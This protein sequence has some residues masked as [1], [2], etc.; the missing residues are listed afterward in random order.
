M[1]ALGGFS[2]TAEVFSPLPENRF[3]PP[4]RVER[5]GVAGAGGQALEPR[6]ELQRVVHR[7]LGR[8]GDLRVLEAGCGSSSHII[9]PADAHMVGIDISPEQLEKN[10]RLDEKI[11]GDVQAHPFDRDSF[12]LIV[13]WDVLEHLPKP[14]D[15][16]RSF[17]KGVKPNG[18]I[19]LAL[20]NVH[21]V[22]GLV[23]KFTPH[24][25]H[26]WFYRR[27]FGSRTA[28]KPGFAP[29]PTFLRLAVSP[30]ALHRF[31]RENGLIVEFAS[32]YESGMVKRIK[33]RSQAFHTV[34]RGVLG[35]VRF[36]SLGTYD[37]SKSDSILV[38]RKPGPSAA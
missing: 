11:L 34:Y 16:L 31:A 20:P 12:D 21:S 25:F 27:I 17:V 3:H 19:V 8:T 37:G 13:C 4:K 32:V 30:P 2:K 14:K 26:V 23:T 18:L 22:K 28:G 1:K 29:F 10:A 33:G 6:A 15:A 35:L 5:A 24:W 7:L 36:L 38:L 9:L